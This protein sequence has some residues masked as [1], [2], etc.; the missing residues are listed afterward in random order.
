MEP[1]KV[2][3]EDISFKEDDFE[4]F[5]LEGTMAKW[6]SLTESSNHDLILVHGM[7]YV[8]RHTTRA[9][10]DADAEA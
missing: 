9:T 3:V 2:T 1:P 6:Y 5:E 4:T 7:G 8:N 10:D